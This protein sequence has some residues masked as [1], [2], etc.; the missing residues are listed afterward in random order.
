MLRLAGDVK[1]SYATSDEGA[2]IAE[3]FGLRPYLMWERAAQPWR[4]YEQGDWEEALRLA[5]AHLAEIERAGGYAGGTYIC[6]AV[7]RLGRDDDSGAVADMETMIELARAEGYPQSV[8]PALNVGAF[9]FA[10]VGQLERAEQLLD[11]V[12][13]LRTETGRTDSLRRRA[14]HPCGPGGCSDGPTSSLQAS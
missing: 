6:R 1:G 12:A 2:A 8:Y 14:D 5:E 4:H 3:R 9:V 11:E 10:S 13:V 7:V